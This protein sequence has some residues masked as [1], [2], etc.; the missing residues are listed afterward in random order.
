[1]SKLIENLEK[2]L[3]HKNSSWLMVDPAV[4]SFSYYALMKATAYL[5]CDQESDHWYLAAD[6]MHRSSYNL[7]KDLFDP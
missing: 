5:L 7:I 2:L 4:C 1:M 6:K 3:P